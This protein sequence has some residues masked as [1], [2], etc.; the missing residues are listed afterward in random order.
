MILNARQSSFVFLFSPNFF[1]KEINDKYE[2]YY[3]SYLLPFES[4]DD[5]M[6]F[7]IQEIDFPG[8][9]MTPVSQT[10]QKGKK[11]DVH[12]NSK[13]VVDLFQREFAITF[14]LTD[15][16]MNYMIWLDN[17]VNFLDFN[18]TQR[19]LDPMQLVLLNNEGYMVSNLVFIKPTLIGQTPLK[20]SQS[21]VTPDF[22]TFT[23]KFRYFDLKPSLLMED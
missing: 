11:Y 5:Y 19:V 17:A 14:K 10:R 9:N 13:P 8:W 21:S 12:K 20:L 6:S 23:A 2:E 1:S 15:S 22:T 16:Y 7:T 3:K 4:V 18:Q